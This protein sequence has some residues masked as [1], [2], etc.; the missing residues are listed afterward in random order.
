MTPIPEPSGRWHAVVFVVVIVV[1]LAAPAA[2][3]AHSGAPVTSLDFDARVTSVGKDDG[4]LR[5]WVI[6]GDRKLDLRVTGSHT[7]VVLGYAD[8]PF[9]RFTRDGVAV[10]QRSLT[11]I[12][13]KLT[14]R[15]SL[16]ALDPPALPSWSMKT[17]RHSFV[18]H[19]H[20]LGPTPGRRYG[21]GDVAAWAIPIVVDGK[22]EQVSGRLWHARGPP[23]WPWLLLLALTLAVAAGLT[24]TRRS[25]LIESVSIGGAALAG[26]AAL[27]LSISVGLAPGKPSMAAWGSVGIACFNATV[28]ITV[29]AFARQARVAVAGLVALFAELIALSFLGTL[30]H[31][32]VIASLPVDV[33]R[34]ATAAAVCSGFVAI[35]SVIVFF[36]ALDAGRTLPARHTASG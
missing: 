17:S 11:A 10:N 27:L 18:W 9:L 3:R 16:P 2:A 26:A 23:I 34:V 5:A 32:Y 4:S 31:G 25:R 22:R 12:T 13:N 35:V 28:G 29:L 14:K 21:E 36:F 20:R 8:E 6:D 1:A 24:R 7:V 33:I 19:D 15:G 30:V